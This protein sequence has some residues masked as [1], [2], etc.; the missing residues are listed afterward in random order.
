M[1]MNDDV[2]W[3]YYMLPQGQSMEYRRTE[4]RE[5]KGEFGQSVH[6][7]TLFDEKAM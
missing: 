1:F 2:K 6:I 3:H 7:G 5:M 4:M